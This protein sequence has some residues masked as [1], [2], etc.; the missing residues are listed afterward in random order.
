MSETCEIYSQSQGVDLRFLD[1]REH[2]T[3]A[4]TMTSETRQPIGRPSE[5][6]PFPGWPLERP[7]VRD[8]D[9]FNEL[10]R[11]W[12]LECRQLDRGDPSVSF[13]QRANETGNF[14]RVAF[15]RAVEQ[16]GGP[17]DGLRTF[18][19]RVDRNPSM[20]WFGRTVEPDALLCFHPS[21][22]FEC[23]SPAGFSVFTFSLQESR[24]EEIAVRLGHP[25]LFGDIR[26]E[27][28]V[29]ARGKVGLAALR[30]SLQ[31]LMTKW[32]D[33]LGVDDAR[34]ESEQRAEEI[35]EDLVSLLIQSDRNPPPA[36]LSARSRAT[37]KAVSYIFSKAK[38]AI[39]VSELCEDAGVSLRTLE[40]AFKENLGASPKR[41][42]SAAR[43][44]GVRRA[45]READP[46]G[47]VASIAN[48]W[49][50]WHMGDFAMNYRRDF[51]E[52]PSETLVGGRR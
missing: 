47:G 14:T 23:L 34:R 17:P 51:G 10:V 3:M 20:E 1:A 8:I 28:A 12:D 7:I 5:A 46:D 29:D 2:G 38:R 9:E 48:D 31:R 4:F 27:I 39:Q 50:F 13:A 26:E 22:Q 11:G 36:S 6:A 21:Q 41:C 37:R 32:D 19:V 49:G 42:I 18:A 33:G 40:R 52:L 43:M 24:L 16:C 35:A 45:L 15:D 44:Q 30:R 25:E